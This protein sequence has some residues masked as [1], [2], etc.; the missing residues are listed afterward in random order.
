MGMASDR[1]YGRRT[2]RKG[3]EMLYQA[4]YV[5]GDVC[6]LCGQ[7]G[8]NSLE[9]L[10]PLALGGHPTDPANQNVSHRTCGQRRGV[11]TLAQWFAENPLPTRDTLKPSREW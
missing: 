9:H 8:A 7:P 10:V 3:Q 5:H 4:L 2:G 11:R 6:V 1:R